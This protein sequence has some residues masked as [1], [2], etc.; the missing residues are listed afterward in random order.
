[1]HRGV[2]AVQQEPPV[3]ILAKSLGVRK[4]PSK[5]SVVACNEFVVLKFSCEIE[6]FFEPPRL[7]AAHWIS[8]QQ[9]SSGH[10]ITTLVGNPSDLNN[11][12]L[13]EALQMWQEP[14]Q[15]RQRFITPVSS[16]HQLEHEV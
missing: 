9:L 4:E 2:S 1:M 10:I 11:V 12:A 5:L 15:Q 14:L 8:G 7:V 13:L 6:P 16:V 3:A